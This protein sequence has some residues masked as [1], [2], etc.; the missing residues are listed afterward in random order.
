VE[1]AGSSSRF[2]MA[3]LWTMS[4]RSRRIQII[5][6]FVAQPNMSANMRVK[7]SLSLILPLLALFL[8]VPASADV[9]DDILEKGTVRFGVAEFVPWTMKSSA[10]GLIGFEI[11]IAEKI[12]AD[13]GVKAELKLYPW[14]EIIPALDRGEFDILAGGMA[15]TP[16]RALRLNFTDSIRYGGVSIATNTKMTKN[17]KRLQELNDPDIVIAVVDGTMAHSVSKTLFNNASINTF[18]AAAAAEKAVIAGQAHVYLAS[19]AEAKFL[20][21]RHSDEIDLPIDEPLL[22]SSEALAVRKGEQE[23]LN[24]LNAW[25]SARQA[26]KWIATTRDYWF[27]TL[28]WTAQVTD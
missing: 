12:A 20:S 2:A 1:R 4:T 11:D 8:S 22:G 23:L 6:R 28:E 16:A 18:A 9:L 13:M 17:I 21:L 19:T 25:I 10:G 27:E 24:F 3:R 14:D 5:A 7:Q 26:D 15:I